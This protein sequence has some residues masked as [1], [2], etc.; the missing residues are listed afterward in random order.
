MTTG[1]GGVASLTFPPLLS[2]TCKDRRPGRGG[3]AAGAPAEVG[4]TIN[5]GPGGNAG[6]GVVVC[7]ADGEAL[8]SAVGVWKTLFGSGTVDSGLSIL[9]FSGGLPRVFPLPP[10]P[11]LRQADD[12][13]FAPC[14]RPNCFA[15]EGVMAERGS[16]GSPQNARPWIGVIADWG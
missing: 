12:T 6:T 13:T 10:E 11:E 7:W 9:R 1:G 8:F 16:G 2:G 14:L 4:V 5:G 15:F 3:R